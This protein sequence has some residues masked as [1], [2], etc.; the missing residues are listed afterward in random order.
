VRE[1]LSELDIPYQLKSAGKGS[2]KRAELA[3]LTGGST[4]CPFLI[5]PN[6]NS[7]ISESKD[8]IQYLYKNYAIFAPPN[9]VLGF[10]SNIITP[11]LKPLFKVLAPLQAGSSSE[12]KAGYE[13]EILVAEAEIKEEN[14]SNDV[15]IYTYSLSPFCSEAVAVLDSLDIDYKEIS[16]GL[17]WVPF[18]ISEEGARKRVALGVMTGQTSLPHV[19]VNGKSIGGLYE[20]LLPS[21]EDGTFQNL[22]K[23]KENPKGKIAVEGSFE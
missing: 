16:L 10:I 19:F 20:G 23:V 17:E 5:D 18:L 15:V 6:T 21:L 13:T 3:R 4:K 8:I 12:N 14:G 7:E 9:E 22:L 11:V 2:S 1:V